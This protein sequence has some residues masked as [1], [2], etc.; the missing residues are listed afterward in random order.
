MRLSF[1]INYGNLA[2]YNEEYF[3]T[4]IALNHAIVINRINSLLENETKVTEE[5]NRE[6]SKDIDALKD[7]AVEIHD[8][9][10]AKVI[11][12]E[13]KQLCL[14]NLIQLL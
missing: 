12:Q 11:I 1:L 14:L 8:N 7:A 9:F 3:L 10:P 6:P 13:R 2:R 5:L 4:E